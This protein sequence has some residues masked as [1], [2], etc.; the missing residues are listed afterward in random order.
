[1]RPLKWDGITSSGLRY[2]GEKIDGV[3]LTK[4]YQQ[5]KRVV[6]FLRAVWAQL[7]SPSGSFSKA[8]VPIVMSK[9]VGTITTTMHVYIMHGL[10]LQSQQ[11]THITHHC[12]C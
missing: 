2:V 10:Y 8:M 6:Q 1:V 5:Q 11:F 9:L 3:G 4:D 12:Y 7:D